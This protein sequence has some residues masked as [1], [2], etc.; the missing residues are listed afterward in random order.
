M[1]LKKL[2]QIKNKRLFIKYIHF[3][4]FKGSGVSLR[5]AVRAIHGAAQRQITLL[6]FLGRSGGP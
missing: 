2:T 1:E 6:D 5:M 4:L 3:K